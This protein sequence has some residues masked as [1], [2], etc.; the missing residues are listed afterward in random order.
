[1]PAFTPRV[2]READGS[3]GSV[4]VMSNDIGEGFTMPAWFCAY[5]NQH[6][7]CMD[8]LHIGTVTNQYEDFKLA[9]QSGSTHCDVSWMLLSASNYDAAIYLTL[10]DGEQKKEK[11]EHLYF[12]FL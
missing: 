12:N 7:E 9:I 5:T 11:G 3:R 1:M 10:A 6:E 4:F 2:V 8:G